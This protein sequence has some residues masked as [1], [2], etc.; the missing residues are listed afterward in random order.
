MR[1]LEARSRGQ[2][3]GPLV[4][5]DLLWIGSS[6][7]LFV[8]VHV[9]ALIYATYFFGSRY[10]LAAMLAANAILVAIIPA[11]LAVLAVTRSPLES[12]N[13]RSVG[14]VIDRCGAGYWILAELSSARDIRCLV[15]RY[16]TM[17]GF[18]RPAIPAL[19]CRGI[20]CAGRRRHTATSAV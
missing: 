16:T 15:A 7:S 18:F 17:V 13:P 12:L 10:G 6:W 3:T 19:S 2:E 8:V 5:D 9:A 20:F 14:G 11:S 1:I 4:V